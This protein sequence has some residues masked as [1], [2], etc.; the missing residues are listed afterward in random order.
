MR[1]PLRSFLCVQLCV[2]AGILARPSFGRT[3]PSLATQAAT[4]PRL[5]GYARGYA[6]GCL[7]AR[8]IL[9]NVM[10][11][12][13][14]DIPRMREGGITTQVFLIYITG[15]PCVLRRSAKRSIRLISFGHKSAADSKKTWRWRL[16]AE[17]KIAAPTRRARFLPWAR[18]RAHDRQDIEWSDLSQ[19]VSAAIGPSRSTRRVGGLSTDKRRTTDSRFW[20]GGRPRN[21]PRGCSWNFDVSEKI[22]DAWKSVKSAV[23]LTL[24]FATFES[25]A[26]SEDDMINAGGKGRVIQIN[27]EAKFSERGKKKK[28]Y[29]TAFAHCWRRKAA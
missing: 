17:E 16:L 26:E 18:R 13:H 28:E 8:S 3:S 2:Y 21:E 5:S 24:S 15:R 27:Y 11:E 20:Q 4:S 1:R 23:S 25:S 12:G 7:P 29:I 19:L 9:A 10:L 22:Y 6:I 14:V